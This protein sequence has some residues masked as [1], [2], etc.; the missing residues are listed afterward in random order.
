[1]K[2]QPAGSHHTRLSAGPPAVPSSS[3]PCYEIDRILSQEKKLVN[4]HFFT[5]LLFFGSVIFISAKPYTTSATV[6]RRC[7]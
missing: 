4:T 1:M 7:K 6:A 3:Q 2:L 5:V